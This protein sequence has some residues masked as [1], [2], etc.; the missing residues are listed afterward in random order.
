MLAFGE[1]KIQTEPKRGSVLLHFGMRTSKQEKERA[2]AVMLIRKIA[3]GDERA[4]VEFYYLY[5]PSLFGM[6]SRIMNDAKEAED[7]LQE[8]FSYIWRKA[9]TFDGERSCPFA[10]AV[11][12]VRH[13]A[14]D[15]LRIRRRFERAEEAAME[16][17]S[18][19]DEV[20]LLSAS[21]PVR[22]ESRSALRKAL[23]RLSQEQRQAL[24]MAFFKGL[25]HEE[26]AGSLSS[27]LG[28]VKARIRRGLLRLRA[29][30]NNEEDP[31]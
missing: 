17:K 18:L 3:G 23:E 29:L 31:E 30:L 16:I 22:A 10:W 19:A 11:M 14:I 7:V 28:T 5:A 15:K 24:E 12:I 2:H 9:A 13:K 8:G 1:P 25:T 21:E 26:I 20:D 4:F 27:P 6:A